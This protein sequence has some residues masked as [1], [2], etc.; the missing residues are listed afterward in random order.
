LCY[1]LSCDRLDT[2][3]EETT[4]PAGLKLRP[5]AHA[6]LTVGLRCNGFLRFEGYQLVHAILVDHFM[7]FENSTF[8]RPFD[9]AS[10]SSV[11]GD[12][13]IFALQSQ[14]DTFGDDKANDWARYDQEAE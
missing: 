6:S 7:A 14:T 5:H 9:D 2:L 10:L 8:W 1:V 13:T 11:Q 4:R 3:F 12:L